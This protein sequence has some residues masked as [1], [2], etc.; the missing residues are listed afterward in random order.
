MA[1][2]EHV[3]NGAAEGAG[4]RHEKGAQQGIFPKDDPVVFQREHARPKI[5]AALH[6]ILSVI[7]RVDQA[8][9]DRIERHDRHDDAHHQ[10]GGIDDVIFCGFMDG[11]LVF[12]ARSLSEQAGI[13]ELAH[14]GVRRHQQHDGNQ[15]L[16]H[17]DRGRE[18]EAHEAHAH[19]E[20]VV[21]EHVAR[22]VVKAV[23]QHVG[24]V[25]VG[26]DRPARKQA[27][28]VQDEQHQHRPGDGW[29]RDVQDALQPRSSR[30]SSPPRT[31]PG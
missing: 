8:V 16:K 15:R 3:Q 6:G 1:V 21:V 10:R 9:V 20:H 28:E 27:A 19:V 4:D 22:L 2:K 31:A 24:L 11:I 18:R 26:A 30:R 17:V 14:D 25:E 29:K 5:N 23:A 12:M 13:R 7:E